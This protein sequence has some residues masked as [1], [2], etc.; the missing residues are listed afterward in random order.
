MPSSLSP[1]NL[2]TFALHTPCLR[3]AP[4]CVLC[5]RQQRGYHLGF[6]P[7]FTTHIKN[8]QWS[9]LP[10]NSLL[11]LSSFVH[12]CCC[13]SSL[14]SHHLSPG[15]LLHT[16]FCHHSVLNAAV[17]VVFLKCIS[18]PCFKP[19]GWALS[20]EYCP[21]FWGWWT[22]LVIIGPL[23]TLGLPSCHFFHSLHCQLY[24][25]TCAPS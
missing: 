25:A 1:W 17:A 20:G 22:K 4:P 24:F 15:L 14:G 3:I 7:L 5:P 2:F 23:F 13:Y 21:W 19:F 18:F 11:N 16:A 10:S 8:C 12:N 6:L 9:L